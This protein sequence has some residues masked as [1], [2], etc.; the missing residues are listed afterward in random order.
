MQIEL[1]TFHSAHF[2]GL[3][4]QFRKLPRK[5]SLLTLESKGGSTDKEGGVFPAF[6][7]SS[8]WPSASTL[9][10]WLRASWPGGLPLACFT[11]H[12]AHLLCPHWVT[13]FWYIKLVATIGFIDK[14]SVE[15]SCLCIVCIQYLPKRERSGRHKGKRNRN[16]QIKLPGHLHQKK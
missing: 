14:F 9:R 3:N 6:I 5:H 13:S 16:I 7:L 2:L 4:W 15:N 10:V 12:S 1:S 8:I 11:H